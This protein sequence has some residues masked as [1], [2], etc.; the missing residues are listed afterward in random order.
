MA[1]ALNAAASVAATAGIFFGFFFWSS[2]PRVSVVIVTAACVGV[3]GALAFARHT[4]FHRSDAA[5]LGWQTDRPDW[6]FE[7][8]FANLAFA[9]MAG[10][11]ILPS[12]SP[13][14]CA[15]LLLGYS[16]YLFQAT[17]LH[18]YRYLTETPR[19]PARL[20]R[21]V[22][23]GFVYAAMMAFFGIRTLAL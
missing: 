9:I 19:S 2:Q 8:G 6:Q 7:V 14:A 11:A 1:A 23:A 21:S 3:V 12:G 16:T 17:I 5:R 10:A 18:L 20:W 15:V 4:V 13:G 22:V